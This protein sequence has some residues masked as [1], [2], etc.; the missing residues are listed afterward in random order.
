MSAKKFRYC[1]ITVI[2]KRYVQRWETST[3]DW[4]DYKAQLKPGWE[5][6]CYWP[7][8]ESQGAKHDGVLSA[9]VD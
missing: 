4:A 1:V 3:L 9:R 6:S 7:L 2:G 8:Q 5:I